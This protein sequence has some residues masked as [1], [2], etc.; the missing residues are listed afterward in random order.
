MKR[1][2]FWADSAWMHNTKHTKKNNLKLFF[3]PA[4][5]NNESI[6]KI[7]S[8]HDSMVLFGLLFS[9]FSI[10]VCSSIA[11]NPRKH[12]SGWYTKNRKYISVITAFCQYKCWRFILFSF[13]SFFLLILKNFFIDTCFGKL[14]MKFFYRLVQFW[15]F[16]ARITFKWYFSSSVWSLHHNPSFISSLL[17]FERID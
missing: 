11:T 12:C 7:K 8:H 5:V 13:L 2:L 15:T 4:I 17:A 10:C 6:S 3:S 9:F 16:I 14:E 1:S